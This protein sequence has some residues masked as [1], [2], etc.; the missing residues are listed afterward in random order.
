[1][2]NRLAF[3]TV[4]LGYVSLILFLSMRGDLG[5]FIRP[6]Y[7]ITVYA[8]IVVL[9]AACIAH[10][11]SGYQ[12]CACHKPSAMFLVR[13][14]VILMPVFLGAVVPSAAYRSL[15][16]GASD[17][18]LSLKETGAVTSTD[19]LREKIQPF[20]RGEGYELPLPLLKMMLRQPA[21]EYDSTLVT[22]TG[23]LKTR[24]G[25]SPVLLRLVLYCCAADAL[26]QGVEL[27]HADGIKAAD[28]EWLTV[29]GRLGVAQHG[30]RSF[31]VEKWEAI[32]PPADP[33][34]T[35]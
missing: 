33:Y 31:N 2:S 11:Q 23:Y 29:T 32:E 16:L 18:A 15:N 20:R 19:V 14:A 35:N 7:I 34:A 4:T 27:H 25:Q 1:M 5:L 28:G 8:A 21:A 10:P 6:S 13:F 3:L 26:P 17:V 22:T 24:P 30:V 12:G 9:I